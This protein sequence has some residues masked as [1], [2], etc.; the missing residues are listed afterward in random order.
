VWLPGIRIEQL[1]FIKDRN[2]GHRSNFFLASHHLMFSCIVSVPRK[3]WMSKKPPIRVTVN[4]LSAHTDEK[5][6]IIVKDGERAALGRQL[7]L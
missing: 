3:S 4:P 7:G 6:T 2:I 1:L 5:I